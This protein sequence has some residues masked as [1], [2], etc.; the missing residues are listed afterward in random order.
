MGWAIHRALFAV[1]GGRVG[2]SRATGDRL[3]TLF[4]LTTGRRTGQV[5]RT[6]LFYLEDGPDLVVIASNAGASADPG[7]WQNLQQTPNAEIQ[8]GPAHRP[9]RGRRATPAEAERLWPR[10][11]AASATYEE[12]RSAAAREMPVVVLEPR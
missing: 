1:T 7:W 9:V 2:A 10:F 6:G 11:V 4:I 12:Y 8:L 3:G 5:R